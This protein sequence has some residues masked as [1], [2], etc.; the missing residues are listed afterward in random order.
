M[1]LIK[2]LT[3]N[4]SIIDDDQLPIYDITNDR[5]RRVAASTIKTYFNED[6][7]EKALDAFNES[8]GGELPVSLSLNDVTG[9]LTLTQKNGNTLTTQINTTG[10]TLD[11]MRAF[12]FGLAG[13]SFQGVWEPKA[14]LMMM[15]LMVSIKLVMVTLKILT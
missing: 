8:S 10:V 3:Q 4:P 15:L 12:T 9:V 5:T 1:T 11:V 7:I 14:V 13:Y 6:V 2:D